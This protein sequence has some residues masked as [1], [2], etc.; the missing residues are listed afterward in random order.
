MLEQIADL[1]LVTD[2][3]GVIEY[4]SPGSERTLRLAPASLL[5][6]ALGQVLHEDDRASAHVELEQLIATRIGDFECEWRL[7][8]GDGSYALLDVRACRISDPTHPR[9]VLIHGRDIS[10]QK[11]TEGRLTFVRSIFDHLYAACRAGV[12]VVAESGD[13]RYYNKLMLEMW[14]IGR[15]EGLIRSELEIW[16]H[17]LRVLGDPGQFL[18]TVRELARDRGRVQT[19]RVLTSTQRTIECYSA[20]LS[21]GADSEACR[22]YCF[23][24]VGYETSPAE[25]IRR[26]HGLATIGRVALGVGRELQNVL[27]PVGA[28]AQL[29][30]S[31]LSKSHPLQ[32]H[33]THILRATQRCRGLIEQLI[34]AGREATVQRRALPI[35]GVVRET[36]GLLRAAVPRTIDL[37][38][39]VSA[40]IPLVEV[41]PASIEQIIFNLVLNAAQ[42]L[43]REEGKITVT[44]TPHSVANAGS[45]GAQFDGEA[46]GLRLTVRDSGE[47]VD[48]AVAERIYDPWFSSSRRSDSCGLG[49]TIARDLVV[50]HGGHISVERLPTVGTAVHVDLPAV[51]PANER[52][53]SAP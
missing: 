10:R 22:F 24:D 41:D 38:V 25:G 11:R 35:G 3:Q 36:V 5:G 53:S 39:A 48:P 47:G 9:R 6:T 20:P 2:A 51:D 21:A 44:V 29:L 17:V 13:V 12:L 52:Q 7:R 27:I 30:S 40:G 46:S 23:R 28:H 16:R 50:R 1:V 43:P 31:E 18:E 34:S 4:V 19:W 33:A 42:A 15:P 32:E 26:L 49:L 8:R 45:L 37:S 14:D